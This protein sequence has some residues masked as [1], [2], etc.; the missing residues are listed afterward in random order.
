MRAIVISEPGDPSVLSW[1]Q[2]PS[3]EPRP[4]EVLL[5]QLGRCL[6]GMME[7]DAQLAQPAFGVP[8]KQGRL[9]RH[10][11]G[12]QAAREGPGGQPMAL[13]MPVEEGLRMTAA[14]EIT[15]TDE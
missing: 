4:G 6:A 14:V 7:G 2:T 3:P 11:G 10:L 12:E 8:R 13:G 1:A 9:V 5:A 15:G